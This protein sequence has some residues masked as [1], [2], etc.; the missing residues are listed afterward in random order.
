MYQDGLQKKKKEELYMFGKS[1]SLRT[2]EP[3]KLIKTIKFWDIE[4]QTGQKILEM[5][6]Q[7]RKLYELH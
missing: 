3:Y 5:K 7:R 1:N 6:R 4:I 2:E